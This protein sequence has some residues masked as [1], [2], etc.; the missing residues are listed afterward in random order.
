MQATDT[1]IDT[2]NDNVA[3]KTVNTYISG[4]MTDGM[5]VPH[6][7]FDHGEHKVS[8]GDCINNQK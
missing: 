5:E 7:V 3:D 8:S 2:E 6:W 1:T 4:T